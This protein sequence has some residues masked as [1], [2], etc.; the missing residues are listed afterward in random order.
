[1]I[2][3]TTGTNEQPF[4][5]LVLEAKALTTDEAL[6]VQHGSSQVPHGRGLWVD[7]LPFEDL[8]EKMGE[9]RVV[10]C[11]A[12]VGSIIMARRCGHRPVVIPRRVHLGEAVDDH[13]L[14][15]GRRLH[16]AGMVTLAEDADELAAAIGVDDHI[17]GREGTLR[18]GAA[19]L[20]AEVLGQLG[21]VPIR[22]SGLV[23]QAGSPALGRVTVTAR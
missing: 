5:R 7:F 15:L 18:T 19:A 13:Q 20:A 11:H 9:A 2:L 10:I 22:R 1:M 3:V 4:D 16:A 12:G 23:D 14:A 8:A 21:R 6:F 17:D